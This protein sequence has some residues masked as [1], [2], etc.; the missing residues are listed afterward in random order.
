MTEKVWYNRDVGVATHGAQSGNAIEENRRRIFTGAAPLHLKGVGQNPISSIAEGVA[1]VRIRLFAFGKESAILSIAN[2][3]W[4]E[5][6]CAQENQYDS[7]FHF[8][9]C[10]KRW[11]AW[12]PRVVGCAFCGRRMWQNEEGPTYCGPDCAYADGVREGDELPF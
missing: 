1:P 8:W 11:V 7:P 5:F 9:L 10:L 3:L 4:L 6:L 12:R 2:K